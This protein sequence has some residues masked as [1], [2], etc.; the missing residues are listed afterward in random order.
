MKATMVYA[1]HDTLGDEITTTVYYDLDKSKGR[2]SLNLSCI[3]YKKK[4][5]LTVLTLILT[6]RIVYLLQV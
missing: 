6:V 1:Y 5:F 3:T 4:I 2:I